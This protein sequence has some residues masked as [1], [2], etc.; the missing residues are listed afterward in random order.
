MSP[1]EGESNAWN[2][3]LSPS[4]RGW[5]NSGETPINKIG[6]ITRSA[7]GLKKGNKDGKDFF[8]GG[9][10][11]SKFKAFEPA[12]I[13]TGTMP[14]GLQYGINIIDNSTVTLVLFDKDK[15]GIID[16][17]VFSEQQKAEDVLEILGYNK[18]KEQ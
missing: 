16:T 1:V 15:N 3:K 13:K 2:I 11:D 10:T 7:D 4:I 12:A 6:I 8:I 9:I 14:S 17:E 18:K 5:F